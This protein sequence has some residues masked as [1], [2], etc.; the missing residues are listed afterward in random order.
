MFERAQNPAL[1]CHCRPRRRRG[2]LLAACSST[3][4]HSASVPDTDASSAGDAS[5]PHDSASDALADGGATGTPPPTLDDFW[6][7]KA[8]FVQSSVF[9]NGS[10]GKVAFSAYNV[11][12]SVVVKDGV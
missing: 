1:R 9:Q 8:Y 6:D 4:S 7:K 11:N 2:G 5:T 12:P 3:E 10:D